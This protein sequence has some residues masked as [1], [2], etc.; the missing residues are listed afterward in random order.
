MEQM[1][2]SLMSQT[3]L[4]AQRENRTLFEEAPDEFSIPFSATR[5]ELGGKIFTRDIEVS[6]GIQYTTELTRDQLKPHEEHGTL[7]ANQRPMNP[8]PRQRRRAR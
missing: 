8:R 4:S 5:P 6:S 3:K 2:K 7:E 1:E